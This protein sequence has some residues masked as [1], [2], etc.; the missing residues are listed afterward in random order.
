MNSQE[1]EFAVPVLHGRRFETHSVPLDVLKELEVYERLIIEVAK[2][3][4]LGR[5]PRR[6][7]VPKGFEERLK[8]SLREVE[9]G[10]AMPILL[11][12]VD[13]TSTGQAT[14]LPAG[15]DEFEEARDLVMAAVR[16]AAENSALPKE[17]PRSVL[18]RFNSF[19]RSLRN[20]E[21]LELR[22]E[23]TE[24]GPKYDHAVRKRLVL[25]EE[26]SFSDAVDIVGRICQADVDKRIFHIQAGDQRIAGDFTPEHN[27]KLLGA[28]QEHEHTRVRLI[29]VGR[30]NVHDRL[31]RIEEIEDVIPIEEGQLDP[32]E[33]RERIDELKAL[34]DGWLDGAG[35]TL[36][37][38]K[39]QEV[40]DL[41]T[42]LH[43]QEELPIPY[44]YPTPSGELQAE[45]TIGSW[46]LS[47]VFDLST[48]AVELDA[49]DTMTGAGKEET[50]NI[51]TP[52]GPFELVRFVMSF[53]RKARS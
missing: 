28:L 47:G 23:R 13:T 35:H 6:Q 39:L 21:A 24:P 46:E 10:S 8:L 18:G 2:A 1:Q 11:R 42:E 49:L 5:N 12:T 22:R 27:Q 4:F 30:Y 9:P 51:G 14:L 44:L 53:N 48:G 38:V 50:V 20:D 15:P 52:E 45:W 32:N 26:K 7:R 43:E 37:S 41:L 33:L 36:D 34:T 25:M 17:F 19:G 29:G 31:E 40:A 16:A 3:V